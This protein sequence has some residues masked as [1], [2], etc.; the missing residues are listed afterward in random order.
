MWLP[1][2]LAVVI[3]SV[4]VVL[5]IITGDDVTTNESKSEYTVLEPNE[6]LYDFS[7]GWYRYPG[8]K[9]VFE[10]DGPFPKM[11]DTM[12]VYKIIRP[13]NVSEAY[14]RE[15]AEKYFD[16]P[17]NAV[18]RLNGTYFNL[19]T[20]AYNFMF[21]AHNGFF[22]IFKHAKARKRLSEDRKDYPSNEECRKIGTEY[23]KERSLLPE[24]TY[25][26]N[27]SD[28][29]I[30]SAGAISVCFQRMIGKYK[31]WG[32]GS[33]ILVWVGVDGEIT[34]VTKRWIEYEPYKL[35]PIKTARE[36]FEHLKHGNAFIAGSGKV[37]RIG[38]AYH[39]PAEG[40]Y[41]QPVYNFAFT[42]PGAVASVPAIRQEHLKSE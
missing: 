16:M 1:A 35:A 15:L 13:K 3:C 4:I 7:A 5:F 28:I 25:L 14:V 9:L 21:Q 31:C 38:L 30:E 27:V 20:N 33:E 36:A 19:D 37:T 41:I 18:F 24:D 17:K 26:S 42:R 34:K 10:F 2:V 32:R 8:R 39:T 23:L 11:P 40:D 12:L 29:N 6:K 22:S